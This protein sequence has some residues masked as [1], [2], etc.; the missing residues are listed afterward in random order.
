MT[1]SC[2]ACTFDNSIDTAV[3]CSVCGTRRPLGKASEKIPTG[4]ESEKA[5]HN[6]D[7]GGTRSTKRK[8][9]KMSQQT[10]FGA[11]VTNR[12]EI[13]RKKQQLQDDKKDSSIQS[14]LPNLDSSRKVVSNEHIDVLKAR[15]DEKMKSIFG[16]QSLRKL[17]PVAVELALKR[18]SQII[19][20]ATGGG[21]SLCY[22]L[23]ASVLGGVTLVISPLIAL[24]VDQVN[25]L[26]KKGVTA[27]LLSS[28]NGERNNKQVM[29]RLIGRHVDKKSK[30][31]VA[32]PLQSITLLYVT[33]ELIQT[34]RFRTVLKELYQKNK[35]TQFAID[36]AHCLSTWG[37]DFRPAYRKLDWLRS[38]F[39]DIPC[40]AC[41]ATATAKVIS[42]IR[43]TLSLKDEEVPCNMS[44]F[45]RPN[46]SYEVRYKDSLDAM[47]PGG[48][49]GDLISFIKQQ[50]EKASN[51][52]YFCSGIVYVHKRQDTSFIANQI[53][54]TAGIQAAPY[55]AGL[56]DADRKMIQ[57]NWTAGK[58]KVAVA[59]VA[60]GMGIDLAHVRYVIHWSMAK[61]VDGFYQESGRAGRD[62]H[63]ALSVLYYSKEDYD[64][65]EFIIA[66]SAQAKGASRASSKN[67]LEGLQQMRN[68]CIGKLLIFG[69]LK[70]F[71]YHILS[72]PL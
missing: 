8:A 16:I 53:T 71:F 25:N 35:L 54:R 30:G 33:P 34:E 58:I 45:N 5:I 15:A 44:S 72:S 14:I 12:K 4:D 70:D 56:K 41:T 39:P 36:E 50:H 29:A 47:K 32:K 68:Y 43:E 1:W 17:Q 20:M 31:K 52:A 64:R 63:D 62:G 7:Q 26:N 69:R 11:T 51:D 23:P 19:V 28:S 2:K 57:E 13:P 27:A 59:T 21:K 37:H 55:H 67:P 60:F 40:M 10:L 49:I 6:L 22:Q 24:M 38:N 18:Q 65:F 66:K 9:K 61:T 46:I 42:D 3:L 48:A